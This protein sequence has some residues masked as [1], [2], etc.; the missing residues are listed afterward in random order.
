MIVND[1]KKGN[2]M[3]SKPE[4]F[5]A[6]ERWM[7]E[8]QDLLTVHYTERFP[9][10]DIPKVISA[11]GTKYLKIQLKSVGGSIDQPRDS[12]RAFAFINLENGDLLKPATWKAPAKHAR[13]NLFDEHGGMKW[14]T[15]YGMAYMEA[16]RS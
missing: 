7:S 1:Q 5:D 4:I 12:F 13:G 8:V 15:P 6:V 3:K 2:V 16:M 10:L 9:T 11:G 14:V